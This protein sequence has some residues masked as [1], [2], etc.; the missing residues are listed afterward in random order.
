MIDKNG[1]TIDYRFE[2]LKE[3]VETSGCF[4][5]SVSQDTF[6]REFVSFHKEN[7]CGQHLFPAINVGWIKLF[8]TLC[9]HIPKENINKPIQGHV[10]W[11]DDRDNRR[12]K[13][14]YTSDSIYSHAFKWAVKQ[15]LGD[16]V[17][18]LT[19]NPYKCTR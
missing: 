7:L 14:H 2:K 12:I 9:I 16:V 15:K 8:Q 13:V 17:D 5:D 1:Y 10:Y 11:P 3:F 4:T 19:M 6:L 18:F